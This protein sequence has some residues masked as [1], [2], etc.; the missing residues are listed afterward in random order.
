[1]F[2]K[3]LSRLVGEE[4]VHYAARSFADLQVEQYLNFTAKMLNNI[5]MVRNSVNDD[6]EFEKVMEAS[7]QFRKVLEKRSD[8]ESAMGMITRYDMKMMEEG[9]FLLLR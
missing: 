6:K 4:N 2:K 1:M 8:T 3:E 5:T 9:R 7:K